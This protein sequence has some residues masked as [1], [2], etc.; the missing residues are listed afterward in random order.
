MLLTISSTRFNNAHPARELGFLLHKNPSHAQVF[1]L[2]FG[3]AHVFYPQAD[4][5]V[6]TCALLL[7]VDPVGLVRKRESQVRNQYVNDRP[8]VASSFLS[9][10]IAQ[11][12]RD[13]LTGKSR[14][15][16][17]LVD[18]KWP[19]SAHLSVVPSRGGEALLRQLFAPFEYSIVTKQLPLDE[20]FPAWGE[21]SYFSLQLN[22]VVRLRDLLSHLYVLLPV[23]DDEKHYYIGDDEVQKLLARGEGWLQTHPSRTL[24]VERYLRRRRALTKSAFEQLTRDEIVDAVETESNENENIEN[25]PVVVDDLA[26]SEIAAEIKP[27]SLHEQRLQAVVRKL[28][29]SGAHRVLDLGCGEGKLLR[30]LLKDKQ[31]LEIVG[32]DVSHRELEKARDRLRLERMPPMQQGRLRFMQGSLTYRDARLAGFDAAAVVEVVEHLEPNRLAAFE[33]VLWEFARPQTIV[34]TTPNRDYNAHWE[35]LPVGEMRHKDHRFE[36]SRDE[37]S[38][39]ANG[40]AEKFG[41]SV[42]LESIGEEDADLGAPSQMAVFTTTT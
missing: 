10:A 6:C 17:E 40:V 33:R 42:L 2:S 12:F 31:F 16:A 35:T 20:K 9:V 30:Y 39:W 26:V 36:W 4:D 18:E 14:E 7:D 41:Y 37:F 28:K 8:Y 1:N 19:F 27:S 5:E 21:S 23:L 22:G 34:L 29:K 32:L 24:I 15:R 11:V 38:M 13:A 25:A 3:R